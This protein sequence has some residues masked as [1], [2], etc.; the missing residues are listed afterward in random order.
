MSSIVVSAGACAFVPVL[1][2]LLEKQQGCK[3]V[4]QNFWQY[5]IHVYECSKRFWSDC[6]NHQSN[7]SAFTKNLKKAQRISKNQK[8][9]KGKRKNF[10]QSET[11]RYDLKTWNIGDSTRIKELPS[12]DMLL[13]HS[14]QLPL[15]QTY[16]YYS[17][18]PGWY[19]LIVTGKGPFYYVLPQNSYYCQ[20]SYGVFGVPYF[21]APM[22]SFHSVCISKRQELL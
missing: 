11:I 3:T 15:E 8:K 9:S 17:P 18:L 14:I 12:E 10:R 22:S 5:S 19:V 7:K 1:C 4:Y 21:Y 16:G 13:Y 2:S 6:K 20:I